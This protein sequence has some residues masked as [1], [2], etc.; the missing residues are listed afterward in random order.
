LKIAISGHE[1]FWREGKDI[2]CHVPIN[3]KQAVLGGRVKVRTMTG[4]VELTVPPGTSAGQKFRLK[5]IGL[6]ADGSRGDQYVEIKIDLPKNLSDEQ[7]Q[8]FEKFTDNLGLK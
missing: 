1:Y 6:S 4:Q 8:L 5:G 3:I 7:R 2:Y